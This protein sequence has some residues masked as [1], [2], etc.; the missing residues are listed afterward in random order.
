MRVLLIKTSSL[1]DVI[2]TWPA[3]SDARRAL[4]EVC[5]DWVVEEAFAEL[6]GWHPAVARVLPVALRRW[7]QWPW[8]ADSRR[9]WE[10]FRQQLRAMYYDCVL[11]AQGLLKSALLTRL[12]RG[13]RCGLDYRSAREPLAALAYQR[14]YAVPRGQ[15]AITRLRQ[16][17]A[18]ALGYPCPDDPPDY[19]LPPAAFQ[20]VPTGTP[21][22]LFLHGTVWPTKQWPEAYWVALGRL[23]NDGGYAVQL[24]W[25]N[26]GERARAERIAAALSRA[27]VLPRLSLRELAGVLAAAAGVVGV[28][29]GLSHLAAALGVPAVTLYGASRADLTG[30]WGRRQRNLRAVFPCAPCLRRR[31]NY[32]GEIRTPSPP[33]YGTLPPATV[34]AALGERMATPTDPL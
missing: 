12:A 6:P 5:F 8:R 25:G 14:R 29:T 20:P 4:P 9:E 23:L 21:T 3:L 26:A 28:D 18:A 22:V 27:Q 17:F 24:P 15:H 2:H 34:W 11:D 1:G 30:T 32:Q 10:K 31:C 16:L 19:G 33:C 13:P 7:R